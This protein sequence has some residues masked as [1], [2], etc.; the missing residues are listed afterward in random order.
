MGAF[1][2]SAYAGGARA[3]VICVFRFVA[4]PTGMIAAFNFAEDGMSRWQLWNR[5]IL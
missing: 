3:N 5:L 1:A 4:R 2:A